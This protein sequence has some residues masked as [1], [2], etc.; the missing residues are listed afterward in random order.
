MSSFEYIMGVVMAGG[1]SS[2]MGTDKGLIVHNS[3]PLVLHQ[4]KVLKPFCEKR[5]ISANSSDYAQFGVDVVAD[6][7]P[8][9]GPMGGIYSVLKS[10]ETQWL[11]VLACDLPY[12]S[13]N[14]VAFLLNHLDE[15]FEIVVPSHN[16]GIEPLFALYHKQ[17][18]T[19]IES[20]IAEHCFSMNQLINSSKH[21]LVDFESFL[22]DEPNLF[23]NFNTPADI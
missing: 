18:L 8:N 5:I 7:V 15:S 12:I 1:K 17:L 11:L 10:L 19:K 20:Q 22:I 2:R 4:L 13:A 21:K 9:I 6:V 14:A 3:Q 23:K 16:M